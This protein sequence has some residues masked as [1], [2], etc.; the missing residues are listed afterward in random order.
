MVLVEFGFH[1]TVSHAF[2]PVHKNKV[3]DVLI[4]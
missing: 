3:Q 2:T 1:L 4:G